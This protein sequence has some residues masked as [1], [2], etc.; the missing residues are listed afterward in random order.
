MRKSE[1]QKAQDKV[2][3]GALL[4]TIVIANVWVFVF[5]APYA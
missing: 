1:T 4:M 5:L 3:M 2:S